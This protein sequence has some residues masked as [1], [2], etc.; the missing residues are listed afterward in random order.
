MT[1]E[2]AVDDDALSTLDIERRSVNTIFKCWSGYKDRRIF[3]YLRHAVCRAEQSLTHQ[4]D[5]TSDPQHISFV[6]KY[7]R[8]TFLFQVFHPSRISYFIYYQVLRKISP[9]EASLLK[10]PTLN[11]RLRFRFAG[12]NYPPVIVYKIFINANVQVRTANL[13][14]R[15]LLDRNSAQPIGRGYKLQ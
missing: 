12:E 13:T 9:Q 8:Q 7:M 5:P 14:A 11:A 3:I 10:D 1:V 2:D 4:V 6:M 15:S